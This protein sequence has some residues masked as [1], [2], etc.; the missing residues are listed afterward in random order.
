MGNGD[1]QTVR[2]RKR[3]RAALAV[4]EA[5]S[6]LLRRNRGPDIVSSVILVGVEKY[7]T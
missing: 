5:T 6:Q 2:P 7:G 1:I 4:R 3:L